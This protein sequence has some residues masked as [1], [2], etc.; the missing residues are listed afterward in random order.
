MLGRFDARAGVQPVR[1]MRGCARLHAPPGQARSILLG[2][3]S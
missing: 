3:M 1:G 2:M